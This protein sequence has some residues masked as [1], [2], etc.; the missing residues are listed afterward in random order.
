MIDV[1]ALPTVI[2]VD[3]EGAPPPQRAGGIGGAGAP[4]HDDDDDDGDDKPAAVSASRILRAPQLPL[5]LLFWCG[6]S[7][8]RVR[9][10]VVAW[11]AGLP[12]PRPSR[13]RPRPRPRPRHW[14]R[15]RPR[16]RPRPR[17]HLWFFRGASLYMRELK[18]IIFTFTFTL[19]DPRASLLRDC[20]CCS[21]TTIP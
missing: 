10:A 20:G 2:D 6:R 8:T 3:A 11:R 17:S 14:S 7:S 13:P 19:P 15:P 9:L 12:T 1:D 16:P 5:P 21:F 4:P 18:F